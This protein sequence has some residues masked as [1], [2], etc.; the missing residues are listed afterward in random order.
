MANTIVIREKQAWKT[1]EGT[2]AKAYG[3]ADG[4]S[5]V[6]LEKAPDFTAWEQERARRA[7]R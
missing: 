6:Q 4:H 1:P 7:G 2:W 5:Q 3:F